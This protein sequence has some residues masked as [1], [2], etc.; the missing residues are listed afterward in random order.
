MAMQLDTER[1]ILH[2]MTPENL[3]TAL[4]DLP[5][6]AK[7]Y[8]ASLPYIGFWEMW[9]KRRIY[10]SKADVI[11]KN[12]AAWL[13]STS[14]LIV[15]R[16]ACAVVGEAG[17]KGPPMRGAVE[18]GYS[19]MEKFRNKGY[20]TEAVGALTRL[21]FS[22]KLYKI[23]R[24]TGLTLPENIA[25]HRVLQKN[26]FTRQPSYGKYWTWER[27]PLPDDADG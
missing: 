1:L 21:A 2:P 13:L 15:D 7:G 14:W 27:M 6:V 11:R 10:K 9:G 18:I 22:Q 17:F 24:V 25:S 19:V 5:A 12:P 26:Q 16:A 4:K 3:K 8:G 20:M 23:D